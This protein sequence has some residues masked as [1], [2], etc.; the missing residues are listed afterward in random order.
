MSKKTLKLGKEEKALLKA[1]EDSAKSWSSVSNGEKKK[2]IKYANATITRGRKDKFLNIRISSEELNA[3]RA[4]A[5]VE[6]IPYQTMVSSV[7]HKYIIGILIDVNVIK[8]FFRS[9]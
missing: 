1:I 6:G 9:R 5:E 3:L 2:H 4:R 7:I 8:P